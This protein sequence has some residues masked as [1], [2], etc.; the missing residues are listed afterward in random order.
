M[1]LP[2]MV[3]KNKILMMDSIIT[4]N[5]LTT[6][7]NTAASLGCL[8]YIYDNNLIYGS[9]NFYTPTMI[10]TPLH[11]PRFLWICTGFWVSSKS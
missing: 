7:K 2:M 1:P 6:Y 11:S 3:P 10:E 8:L 4:N 9:L 5:T